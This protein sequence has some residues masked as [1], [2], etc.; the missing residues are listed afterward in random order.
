MKV[1]LRLMGA[2]AKT[3]YISLLHH[4]PEAILDLRV[5]SVQ[6]L[7][8]RF[9]ALRRRLEANRKRDVSDDPSILP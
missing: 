5:Q 7:H 6:L 2:R 8:N 4:L 3:C 1:V 9:L